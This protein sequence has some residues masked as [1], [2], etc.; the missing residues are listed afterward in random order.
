MHYVQMPELETER[1]RLRK[2][3][4]EDI[5]EYY[6]RLWGDGDVCRY[7]LSEPHQDIGESLASIERHLQRYEEGNYYYWGAAL[8]ED[9]SLIGIVALL[10]LTKRTIAAASPICWAAIT[11]IRAT[12][13]KC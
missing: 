12:E 2:V 11:G 13:R 5:C 9:D 3:R 10:R 1:L 6:E 4:M 8:K 7:L